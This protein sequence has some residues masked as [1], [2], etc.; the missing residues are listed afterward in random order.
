MVSSNILGEISLRLFIAINFEGNTKNE[1]Q[2]NIKE[3]KRYSTQ[4]KFVSNEH[5]HLTLEFL[6]EIPTDK[7]E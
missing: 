1:I 2:E 5:M 3:V 4:G 7:V 6:G